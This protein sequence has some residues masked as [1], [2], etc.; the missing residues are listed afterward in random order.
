MKKVIFIILIIF[1]GCVQD[2]TQHYYVDDI[3]GIWKSDILNLIFKDSLVFD[4]N[5]G[6][7]STFLING[8]TLLMRQIPAKN[9]TFNAE[10]VILKLN[11]DTLK[12]VPLEQ[13]PY[14]LSKNVDYI[15]F[16]KKEDMLKE[17]KTHFDSLHFTS[18]FCPKDC[19]LFSV[20]VDFKGNY[21]FEGETNNQFKGVYHKIISTEEIKF[22]NKLLDD[23]ELDTIKKDFTDGSIH[24]PVHTLEIYLNQNTYSFRINSYDTQTPSELINMI[25]YLMNSYK[26]YNLKNQ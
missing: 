7:A 22:I 10:Y 23:L 5:F 15:S 11:K 19:S 17:N 12:L 18:G 25:T 16:I 3:Q 2:H 26:F 24:S 13:A 14:S 1:Q 6:P 9:T 21:E 20:K 4:I 8:D